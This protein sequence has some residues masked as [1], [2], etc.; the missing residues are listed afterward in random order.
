MSRFGE[1]QR[2][3][4]GRVARSIA[5][6]PRE[7]E[8]AARA[9]YTQQPSC[10]IPDLWFLYSRFLGERADGCFV[11]VGAYDGVLVSNTWGLAEAGWRGLMIEP[12]PDLARLCRKNHS[13]HAGITVCECAIGS[14][15]ADQATMRLA[16]AG[17]TGTRTLAANGV[18]TAL[19]ITAT[20]WI[21]SGTNL[22]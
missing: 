21:I 16:G 5:P 8:A 9:Y 3:V 14:G 13:N 10:Q 20:E 4:R 17:T 19:K 22:T 1:L 7:L 2:R 11:E 18:A 6:R 12:V 15:D